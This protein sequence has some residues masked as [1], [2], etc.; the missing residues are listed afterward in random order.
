MVSIYLLYLAGYAMKRV[1]VWH[2]NKSLRKEIIELLDK[3]EPV[4][5]DVTK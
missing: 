5:N 1:E 4:K 2:D 3:R